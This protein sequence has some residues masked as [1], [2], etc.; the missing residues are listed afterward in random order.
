[1]AKKRKTV[2]VNDV[3]RNVFQKREWQH[4][5]SVNRVFLF[6]DEVVGEEIAAYAQPDVFKRGILWVK[7]IDS[8]RMHQLHFKKIELLEKINQR[9]RGEIIPGKAL[10][11][12]PEIEDIRFDIAREIVVRQ[13]SRDPE[14]VRMGDVDPYREEEFDL[15]IKSIENKELRDTMRRVWRNFEKRLD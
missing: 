6:W 5:L 3:L 7:V 15:L 8:F 2:L 9:L 14:P 4:R 10:A 11:K 12:M 13:K 1:M